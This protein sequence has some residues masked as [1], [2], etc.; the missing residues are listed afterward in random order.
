MNIRNLQPQLD[1]N[2]R[3]WSGWDPTADA[4]NDLPIYRSDVP[5]PLMNGVLRVRDRS[6]DA[7]IAEAKARLEGTTWSWWVGADSDPGTA[8][9]LL[10]RGAT[11]I[12]E[13]PIM[14]VDLEATADRRTPDGMHIVEVN[15]RFSV[16]E[17]TGAYAG[18]LGFT[19]SSMDKMV[20]RELDRGDGIRLAGILDGRIVGTTRLALESD[21]AGLYFVA[22][23][24]AYRRRGVAS[25][26][27]LEAT[28]IA[29]RAGHRTMTLQAS[30]EGEPVYR[31]VGF[32]SVSRY[33]LFAFPGEARDEQ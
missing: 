5:H 29:R 2:R 19:E 33:R 9:G 22:T 24:P 1:A 23:D 6:L 7:A 25:A 4:D 12:D 21:V 32:E 10:E 3:F 16:G 30:S 15:D 27:T 20:E 26:L 8:E 13:M 18:P 14:A 11:P 17:F 28:R 31:N